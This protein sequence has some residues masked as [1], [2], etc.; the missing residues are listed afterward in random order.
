VS[1]NRNRD[2]QIW[3]EYELFKEDW[4]GQVTSDQLFQFLARRHFA[5]ENPESAFTKVKKIVENMRKAGKKYYPSLHQP[6]SKKEA[7]EYLGVSISTID[8]LRKRGDLKSQSSRDTLNFGSN[9]GGQVFFRK[10][11]LD[12][13][14]LNKD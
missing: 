6:M 9:K 13:Y 4:K 7:S 8:R 10:E 12:A 3:V 1:R 14:L 5:N 2:Q 11:W